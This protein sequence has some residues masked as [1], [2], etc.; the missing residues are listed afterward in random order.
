MRQ[1]RERE[2]QRSIKF[3]QHFRRISSESCLY[4]IPQLA[5]MSRGVFQQARGLCTEKFYPLVL[6]FFAAVLCRWLQYLFFS[7]SP[8]QFPFPAR[9]YGL[10]VQ[11]SAVGQLKEASG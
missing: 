6:S 3:G 4:Y 2:I 9:I 7:P 10:S 8:G 5:K 1:G 11:C